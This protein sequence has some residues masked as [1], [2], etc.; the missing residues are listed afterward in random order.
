M[1]VTLEEVSN[2]LDNSDIKHGTNDDNTKIIFGATDKKTIG[3]KIEIEEDGD[4]VQVYSNLLDDERDI[5]KI[6]DHEHSALVLQHILTINYNEKF[7]GWEFDPKDGEIRF[8]VEI[9]LEDAS[10]TEKQFNRILGHIMNSEKHFLDILKIM[11]TGELP[12]DD[13]DVEDMFNELMAR[14]LAEKL[15]EDLEKHGGDAEALLA[16]LTS[17]KEGKSDEGGI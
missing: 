13:N 16:E 9:P 8:A 10:M 7:G 6:K 2:W 4:L 17:K 14:M 11:E 12:E 3:I 15:A 5:L 1:A